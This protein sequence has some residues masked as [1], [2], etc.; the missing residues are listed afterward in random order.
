MEQSPTESMHVYLTRE[1]AITD[2][3][4]LS[5]SQDMPAEITEYMIKFRC[6][7]RFSQ[8]GWENLN[9]ILK[10]FF[11]KRINYGRIKYRSNLNAIGRW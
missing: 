10:S 2:S 5:I 6:L 3:N 1:N 4:R 7:Y 8:Q 11:F 9:H